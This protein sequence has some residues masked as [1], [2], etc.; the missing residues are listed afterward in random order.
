[1]LRLLLFSSMFLSDRLGLFEQRFSSI[2][3]ER[4]QW[5]RMVEQP[6]RTYTALENGATVNVLRIGS[7]SLVAFKASKGAKVT[8]CNS[9][10][11]FDEGFEALGTVTK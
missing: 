11:A 5:S 3:F 7:S 9:T 4:G 2:N 6:C 8:V 10:A 1:M